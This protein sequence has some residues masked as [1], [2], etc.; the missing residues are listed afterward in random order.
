MAGSGIVLAASWIAAGPQERPQDRKDDVRPNSEMAEI[1]GQSVNG[2]AELA[3]SVTSGPVKRRLPRYHEALLA[4][5]A[6]GAS[7]GEASRLAGVSERTSQ[8]WKANHRA[9]VFAARRGMLDGLLTK[10][11]AALPAALE[12]LESIAKNSEDKGVAVR[13]SGPVGH[14]RTGF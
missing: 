9:E 3:E 2:G 13:A 7:V 4:A 11:R 12:R 14:L 1:D 8:R 10:V 6:M 5:F